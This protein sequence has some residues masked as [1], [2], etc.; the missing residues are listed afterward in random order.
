MRNPQYPQMDQ[1]FSQRRAPSDASTAAL[2]APAQRDDARNRPTGPAGFWLRLTSSG[3]KYPP[4]TFAEREF[5]RRSQ[6]ASWLFLGLLVAG[7]VF[8]S[9]GQTDIPTLIAI[10]GAILS[11]IVACALNRFG[12]VTA[13]ALIVIAVLMVAILGA[14]LSAPGGQLSPD[15]LASYDLLVLPML[16]AAALLSP[17]VAFVL[18]IINSALIIVDFFF[19]QTQSPALAQE[20]AVDGIGLLLGR[21]IGLEVATAAIVYLLVRGERSR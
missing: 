13:A 18:V 9:A 15:Y 12:Q 4:R 19:L 14:D 2:G 17:I 6:L 3:W 16:V 5:T 10:V 11:V 21:P 20:V 1:G 7:L 8:L